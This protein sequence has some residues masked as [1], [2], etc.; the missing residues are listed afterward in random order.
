[1]PRYL[2]T[3]VTVFVAQIVSKESL[4]KVRVVGL[5]PVFRNSNPTAPLYEQNLAN[6]D[7]F[8]D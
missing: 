2:D 5:V 7:K 4:L 1:M 6:A 8:R 3:D